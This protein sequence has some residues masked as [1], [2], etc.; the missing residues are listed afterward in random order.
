MPDVKDHVYE[1]VLLQIRRVDDEGKGKLV[2]QEGV[3]PELDYGQ[4][5]G[6]QNAVTQSDVAKC[7]TA[8]G[9][10]QAEANGFPE[11]QG[12]WE[13]LFKGR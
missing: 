13:S 3:W 9:T 12:G 2:F 5:V 10:A 1:V 6:I 7:L 11:P 8:L 4:V